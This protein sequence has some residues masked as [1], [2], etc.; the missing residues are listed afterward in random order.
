M[1]YQLMKRQ[2]DEDIPLILSAYRHP[3]VS[4]FIHIDENHY[5]EYVT[6]SANVYF[7]KVYRGGR[8]AA[9]VHCELEARVLYMDIV[10]FPEYQRHGIASE[11]LTDIQKGR[12]GFDFDKIQVAIDEN[13][14]ASRKL[15]ETAD[16][17]CISQEDELLL[18]EYV[19]S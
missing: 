19:K 5:W 10:V 6:T 1:N 4:R 14:V 2:D 15:F 13:N 17:R 3:S 16:F 9:A 12:L 11:V 7:Y 18:Y 8:L